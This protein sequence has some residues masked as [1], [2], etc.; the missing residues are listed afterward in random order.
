MERGID[1][2]S[3]SLAHTYYC[4]P[5]CRILSNAELQQY[6]PKVLS[7]PSYADG[8]TKE[9][10]DYQLGPWVAVLDNFLTDDE[11]D[12]LIELGAM[13]GYNRSSDVGEKQE[14]GTFALD[15]NR[16]VSYF[17]ATCGKV[18]TLLILNTD[19]LFLL[20]GPE[21]Q[22]MPGVGTCVIT[23]KSLKKF[24]KKWPM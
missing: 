14:D 1:L 20:P 15:F 3:F 17:L 22:R 24:W 4:L 11:C 23:I 5:V 18:E 19:S 9:T 10:A 6:E 13:E 8:D 7:R 21:L 2:L 12:R 16:Y